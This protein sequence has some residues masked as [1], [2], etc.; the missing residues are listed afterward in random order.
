MTQKFL[1]HPLSVFY[2]PP[3]CTKSPYRQ[4]SRRQRQKPAQLRVLRN[5]PRAMPLSGYELVRSEMV[6][7]RIDSV[8]TGD[9][10]RRKCSPVFPLTIDV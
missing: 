8:M 7:C 5:S 1:G 3:D 6:R 2:P 4:K 10:V 9:A